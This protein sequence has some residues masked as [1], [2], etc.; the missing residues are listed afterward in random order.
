M[1]SLD[2]QMPMTAVSVDFAIQQS[3]SIFDKKL[4]MLRWIKCK[5]LFLKTFDS[6]EQCSV[7]WW[8]GHGFIL[9]S[10]E[11]NNNKW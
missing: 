11:S 8:T 2:C 3:S 10:P 5:P 4:S 9:I 1:S 7:S 6:F